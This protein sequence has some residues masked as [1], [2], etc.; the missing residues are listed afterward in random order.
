MGHS[1]EEISQ[2][3]TPKLRAML[4][5]YDIKRTLA[6]QRQ[7]MQDYY[8]YDMEYRMIFDE[9]DSRQYFTRNLPGTAAF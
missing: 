1:Y 9:L 5:E 3:S 4:K 2:E 8:E 7:E 6:Q